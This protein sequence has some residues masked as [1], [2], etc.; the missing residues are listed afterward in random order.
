MGLVLQKVILTQT[1]IENL[2]ICVEKE[3]KMLNLDNAFYLKIS[4]N[5]NLQGFHKHEYHE[6]FK[7][8]HSDF[9]K[10]MN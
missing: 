1:F 7:L 8:L 3:S 9:L 2:K 10:E 4:I 6:W 5:Y